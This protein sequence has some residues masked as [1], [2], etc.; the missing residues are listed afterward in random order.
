MGCEF[1]EGHIYRFPDNLE[2]IR[3]RYKEKDM[4]LREVRAMQRELL[5]SDGVSRRLA[6][7]LKKKGV[8]KDLM[9]KEPPSFRQPVP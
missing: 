2:E 7:N 6:E 4:N 8:K 3:L 5:N 1:L 9:F